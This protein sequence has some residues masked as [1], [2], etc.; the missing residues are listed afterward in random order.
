MSIYTLTTNVWNACFPSLTVRVLSN[1]G[2]LSMYS[3]SKHFYLSVLFCILFIMHE[4]KNIFMCLKFIYIS[5]LSMF[6]A[7]FLLGYLE[8]LLTASDSCYILGRL[9]LCDLIWKL[10]PG[11]IFILQLYFQCFL[12]M[13]SSFSFWYSWTF[14]SYMASGFWVIEGFPYY[15]MKGIFSFFF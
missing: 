12:N 1:F 8:V 9:L 11:L 10:F 4:A 14:W 13:Q 6:F 3:I 7:Y 5:C 15:K 2:F